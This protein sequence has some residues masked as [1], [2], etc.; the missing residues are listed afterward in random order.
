MGDL[1]RPDKHRD[2]T[3]KEAA[4]YLSVSYYWLWRRI[5][6]EGG[7]PFKRRDRLVILPREEFIAWAAPL[8]ATGA[9]DRAA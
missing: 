5:G 1:P 8:A 2:L 4:W 3:I 9:I 6:T 7:P